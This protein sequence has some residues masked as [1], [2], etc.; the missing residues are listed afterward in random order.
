MLSTLLAN[1]AVKMV[2]SR[3]TKKLLTMP[4]SLV[5]ALPTPGSYFLQTRCRRRL[6]VAAAS[7]PVFFTEDLN[8]HA[9][10][11]LTAVGGISDLSG[12][13][14]G[15]LEARDEQGS[16]LLLLEAGGSQ[17]EEEEEWG[18]VLQMHKQGNEVA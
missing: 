17:D 13:V 7:G 5:I 4:R 2:I 8:T 6:A 16:L 12:M 15:I 11:L 9:K 1:P 18:W 10:D 3:R 14:D